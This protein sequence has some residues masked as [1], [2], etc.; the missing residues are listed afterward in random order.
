MNTKT[1]IALGLLFVLVVP[2]VAAADTKCE[3]AQA[4]LDS[5][6]EKI[7]KYC[8]GIS[9]DE[10]NCEKYQKAAIKHQ[11]KVEKFCIPEQPF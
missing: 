3:K 9:Y 10:K 5:T 11:T 2:I 4:K 7:D 1:V 6:Y 8:S